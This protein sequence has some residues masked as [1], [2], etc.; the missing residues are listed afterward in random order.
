V[1]PGSFASAAARAVT[2]AELPVL[3]SLVDQSLV[4]MSGKG[5]LSLHAAIRAC[6]RARCPV[7]DRLQASYTLHLARQ[8]GSVAELAEHKTVQPFVQ[9]LNAEWS[10]VE[11]AWTLALQ[12]R[13]FHSLRDLAEALLFQLNMID[14]GFDVGAFYIRAELELRHCAEL[15]PDLQA[16]LLAGAARAQWFRLDHLQAQ[17]LSRRG[18]RAALAARHRP[19]MFSSLLLLTELNVE[20]GRLHEAEAIIRRVDRMS[21]AAG[22][23]GLRKRFDYYRAKLSRARGDPAAALRYFD[24]VIAERQRLQRHDAVL[25]AFMDKADTYQEAG[26]ELQMIKTMEEALMACGPRASRNLQVQVLCSLIRAYGDQGYAGF[27]GREALTRSYLERANT[28]A[29]N[30]VL[31]PFLKLLLQITNADFELHEGRLEAAAGRLIELLEVLKM[32]QALPLAESIFL[33]SAKWFRAVGD[34]AAFTSVLRHLLAST[35]SNWIATS[36]QK[37]LLAWG[38]AGYSQPVA[39][40][41]QPAGSN[42][43]VLDYTLQRLRD[44]LRELAAPAPGA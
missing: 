3:T 8:L 37:M 30:C 13:D 35:T 19:A 39:A 17:E 20:Q 21:S 5:R 32:G 22:E 38:E 9:F 40:P 24:L 15:P 1:F 33:E 12:R 36:A 23:Q 6:V 7:Q 34:G 18:L 27:A 16:L 41:G 43:Q 26:D 14:T 10:N 28:V 2:G 25:Y 31:H 11:H 4:L 29:A 42:A 44:R